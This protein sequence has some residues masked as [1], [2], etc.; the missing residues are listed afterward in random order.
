MTLPA[1]PRARASDLAPPVISGSHEVR[2]LYRAAIGGPGCGFLRRTSRAVAKNKH[3]LTSADFT[4]EVV[5][6]MPK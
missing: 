6:E 4:A 3:V 1:A 5:M 2:Y